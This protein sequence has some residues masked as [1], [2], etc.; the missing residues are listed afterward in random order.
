MQPP[1]TTANRKRGPVRSRLGPALLAS[2]LAFSNAVGVRAEPP[3]EGECPSVV[4]APTPLEGKGLVD[5]PPILLKEGMLI[6][7]DR[8]LMLRRL[9]PSVVWQHREAFFFE[10]MQME[11]GGCHRR[12]PI[13]SPYRRATEQL[14]QRAK[15]DKRGNLLHSEAGLPFPP[16]SINPE[17]EQAAAKWAWN[18]E[19]RHRGAGFRG[20]FRITEIPARIGG[21]LT[22]EGS[23]FYL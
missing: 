23:F 12:Y 3:T 2:A 9:L 22:Y 15:L 10:G 19:Q 13:F 11:I 14:N 8:L 16:E 17:D 7:A 20:S 1:N 4:G 5:A 6:E 18:L 21:T